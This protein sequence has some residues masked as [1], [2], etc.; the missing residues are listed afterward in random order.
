MGLSAKM[1]TPMRRFTN[2]V[3]DSGNVVKAMWHAEMSP[4]GAQ[5]GPA[6]DPR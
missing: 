6:P 5:N 1:A 2:W 3:V 4:A